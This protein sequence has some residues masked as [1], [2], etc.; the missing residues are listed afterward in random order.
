VTSF[1]IVMISFSLLFAGPPSSFPYCRHY[2]TSSSPV[3]YFISMVLIEVFYPDTG[4]PGWREKST[5]L[6]RMGQR[7]REGAFGREGYP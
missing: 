3:Q 2:T 6:R 7:G 1:A 4:T 5:F